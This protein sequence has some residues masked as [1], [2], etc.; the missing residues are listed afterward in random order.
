MTSG[1]SEHAE[2][3][4]WTRDA[5]GRR[6]TQLDPVLMHLTHRRDDIPANS[7]EQMASEVGIGLNRGTRLALWSAL[8]SLL[9]LLIA[10]VICVV[11]YYA[12]TLSAGRFARSLIPYIAIVGSMTGCWA[13][14]RSARHQKIGKAMLAH[15]RCPHCADDLRGL[16]ASESDGATICPE[17]G[18]AWNLP[19]QYPRQT[20]PSP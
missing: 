1:K 4:G 8:L 3:A 7:L 17:C 14:L 20:Q 9:C 10:I 2:P 19:A 5:R 13:S 18:C 11:R 12:G 15:Q 6:V 16:P